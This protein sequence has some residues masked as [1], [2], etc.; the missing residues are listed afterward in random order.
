MGVYSDY[1]NQQLSFEELTKERKSQLKRISNIRGRDVL[2]FASDVAKDCPNNID[3]SDIVPFSD[4]L[5]AISGDEIDIVLETPGGFAEVVEDLVKLIRSRFNKVGIIVP[6][7]AKSAGTIFTMAADEILMGTTSALGP[8]DAQMSSNGKRFSA[9]AFLA[10][11]N[12][13]RKEAEEKKHLDI[14]YI[15]ILQNISPGEIQHCENAQAFSRTLV[16]NWLKDYKF[17]FWTK[18]SSTGVE[19][20]ETEKKERANTIAT[21][22]C[23]HGHWLTHGRSIKL[24]DL[25]EMGLQITDYSKIAELNDA[26]TK[27]YTLLRMSFETNI[28]KIYET[29]MSQIYR[30]INTASPPVQMQPPVLPNPLIIDFE[31]GKCHAKNKIQINFEQDFPLQ[32]GA[33]PFPKDNLFKCP[34]CGAESDLLGFRQQLEVQTRKNIV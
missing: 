27:Y 30:S 24:P 20:T 16:T 28:Y 2:V 26:I 22:L 14:A 34:S 19:V 6:G 17:K 4:Q 31:C 25:T 9:D 3:Y 7:M 18:H 21:L 32:P 33:F 1:L 12:S 10:G 13:I 11:L 23:N 5:S 15:P 8:I 29:P